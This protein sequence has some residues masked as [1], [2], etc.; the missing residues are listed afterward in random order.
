MGKE[1]ITKNRLTTNVVKD[2][3]LDDTLIGVADIV[4]GTLLEHCGP[5][6]QFATIFGDNGAGQLTT[7]FTKDGIGILRSIEFNNAIDEMIMSLFKNVGHG[8]ES[9]AGDGTTSSVIIAL[10]AIKELRSDPTL[11]EQYNYTT[12]MV[13]FRK[14]CDTIEE[15]MRLHSIKPD[16]TNTELL[17]GIAYHQSMTSAHGDKE[18]SELVSELIGQVHP[19]AL[20]HLIYR[21]E[22]I[23]TDVRY[24]LEV[25]TANYKCPAHL[26]DQH[27]YNTDLGDAVDYPDCTIVLPPYSLSSN[28]SSYGDLKRLIEELTPESDPLAIIVPPMDNAV[29]Q[30]LTTMY[31]IK[32]RENC[33]LAVFNLRKG[34]IPRCDDLTAIFAICGVD[35]MMNDPG[36]LIRDHAAV[37]FKYEQL[38]IENVCE[39]TEDGVHVDLHT[40]GTA[41]SRLSLVIDSSI[42]GYEQQKNMRS[43]VGT[44]VSGLQRVRN[45]VSYKSLANVVIGGALYEQQAN[46][47]VI[48]DVLQAV[49]ESILSGVALGGFKGLLTPL[50]SYMGVVE[51]KVHTVLHNGVDLV[52]NTFPWESIDYTC[53]QDA[54]D[55]KAP[56]IPLNEDTLTS[57]DNMLVVQSLTSY[58]EFFKRLCD[59]VPRMVYT[60]K[61]IVPNTTNGEDSTDA[62]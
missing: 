60:N 5:N 8:M 12:F 2:D 36:L 29:I 56:C 57:R 1:S 41:L 38:S 52:N 55:P 44:I 39:Y 20:K 25:E 48:K 31:H 28:S 51:A 54:T 47:D 49:R 26:W 58:N 17:K 61:I 15:N 16:T 13:A 3:A 40:E 22:P 6:S 24:R 59:V 19:L 10:N 7:K 43:D 34:F 9:K 30:E 53:S 33:K 21:A 11:R 18:L 45:N 23:E 4:I 35:N 14:A 37:R 46:E 32:R 50:S 62:D 42:H 27:M